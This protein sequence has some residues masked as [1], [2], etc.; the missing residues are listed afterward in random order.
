MRDTLGSVGERLFTSDN[1]NDVIDHVVAQAK[2]GDWVVAMSNG[3]FG[4]VHQK[5]MDALA[6]ANGAGV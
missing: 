2:P 1:L 3:S 4:G 5:L 6:N